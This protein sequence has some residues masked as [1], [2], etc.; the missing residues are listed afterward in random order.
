MAKGNFVEYIVSDNPNKYPDDGE[1][2]GYYYVAM[3]DVTPEVTTQ[4]PIIQNITE[5]LVG[6]AQGATATADKI[7]EG[8]SAYVNGVLVDGTFNKEECVD[9]LK[10]LTGYSKIAVDKV[11]FSSEINLNSGTVTIPHSLGEKPRVMILACNKKLLSTAKTYIPFMAGVHTS[12]YYGTE[13]QNRGYIVLNIGNS[14][15]SDFYGSNAG[16]TELAMFYSGRIEITLGRTF[17][18]AAGVEYTLITM[19]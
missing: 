16:G 10:G 15:Y 13:N 9:G 18:I 1:Q 8:Y 11:T 7:L 2:S 19:A 14:S 3:E 17:Y 12:N 6:K 5:A 4:T